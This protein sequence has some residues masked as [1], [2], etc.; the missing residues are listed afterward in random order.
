[1]R[2]L[3]L[4]FGLAAPLVVAANDGPRMAQGP[5]RIAPAALAAWWVP[6]AASEKLL[7]KQH[8]NDDEAGCVTVAFMIDSDGYA[9]QDKVL[10]SAPDAA[11]DQDALKLVRKLR[12]TAAAENTDE[13]AVSTWRT[14]TWG[15]GGDTAR[16]E[17]IATPCAVAAAGS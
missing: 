10:S 16:A 13:V 7:S 3:M 17:S 4:L 1:M 14:F 8:G 11:R 15:A 2:A 12:Y 9:S 5:Q 6:N